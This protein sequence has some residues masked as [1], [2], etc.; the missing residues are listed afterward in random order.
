M[1]LSRACQQPRVFQFNFPQPE[2]L[3]HY[4]GCAAIYIVMALERPYQ[5]MSI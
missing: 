4:G 3:L 5:G 2:L 1:K